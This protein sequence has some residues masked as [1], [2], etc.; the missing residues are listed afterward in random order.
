MQEEYVRINKLHDF[1]K[2]ICQSICKIINYT[3]ET[4]WKNIINTFDVFCFFFNLVMS[5]KRFKK[6]AFTLVELIFVAMIIALIMPEMFSLYN[7][8]IKSNK[9]IIARQQAIQQWYEFFERLNI[10]MEDYTIDYEEYYNRQMVGCVWTT[11]RGNNFKRNVWED[12]YCTEFTAYGNENSFLN[13]RDWNE[14]Y[15]CSSLKEVSGSEAATKVVKSLLDWGWYCGKLPGKQSYGQYA[16]LFKDVK[17]GQGII[18]WSEDDVELWYLFNSSVDAIE[19]SDNI[20][21]LYLISHDWDRRL[22]FRR[23]LDKEEWEYKQ[24]KIQML[25]LRWFDAWRMHH[26]DITETNGGVK[27]KW[28]YDGVIDTWACDTSMWFIWN[29]DSID[30][31]GWAYADYKL[32]KDENDCWIDLTHWSTDLFS[33]KI[34]ISPKWD[35]DL[36]WAD[37]TRQINPYM[38]IMIINKIYL[39]AIIWSNMRIASTINDFDVPLET[40]INM[41]DFYKSNY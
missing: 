19:D 36:Y 14:I 2:S 21:E 17:S 29:W 5:K 40:T 8:I 12:W 15:Y 33:W 6:Y 1:K 32:P 3:L 27:N 31:E 24:Y 23:I 30:G 22:Y 26:F 11:E 20:Q 4:F 16:A 25:R 18:V 7:F 38:K 41:K 13:H 34:S 10:L 39:P 35:S 37:E 28:L 9:E